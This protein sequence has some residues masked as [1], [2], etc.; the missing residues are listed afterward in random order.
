[1]RFRRVCKPERHSVIKCLRMIV[2]VEWALLAPSRVAP[3]DNTC[4]GKFYLLG[5]VFYFKFF[6]KGR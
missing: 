1:M 4:P 2:R 5:A 3:Q 6:M